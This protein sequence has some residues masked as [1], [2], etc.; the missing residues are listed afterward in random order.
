MNRKELIAESQ[1]FL[2]AS[3]AGVGHEPPDIDVVD[4][5]KTHILVF[6]AEHMLSQQ[7]R[8][9]ITNVLTE[10]KTQNGISIPHIVLDSSMSLELIKQPVL[11]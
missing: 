5:S 8:E 4:I 7:M 11:E 3:F 2:K 9:R 10:W 6:K 1:A